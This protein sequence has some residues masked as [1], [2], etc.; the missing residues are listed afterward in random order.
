M[1]DS[2]TNGFNQRKKAFAAKY[3]H[4][5]DLTFRISAR[6]NHLFGLWA[7]GLLG[8]TPEKAEAYVEEVILADFQK[9]HD[10]DVFL[11]VL[12]DLEAAKVKISEH[13]V[14]KEFERCWVKA[15]KMIM[16]GEE[17]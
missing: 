13:R 6:R 2:S 9:S 4:D 17:V 7:A 10:K 16:H 1:G 11:K 15:E 12:G 3:L 14:H 5:E 8:Y